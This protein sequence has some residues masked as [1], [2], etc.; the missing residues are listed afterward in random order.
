ML[1]TY[2]MEVI[3]VAKLIDLTGQRFGHLIVLKK[4]E[5]KN[6]HVYWKCQCDCGQI[7]EKTG[8]GLRNGEATHCGCQLK[9]TQ[10]QIAAKERYNKYVGQRFGRLIVIKNTGKRTS[11]VPIWLC[12]CDCGNYKEVP[13]NLLTSGHTQSCGCLKLETHLIDLTGQKIGK[14]TVLHREKEKGTKWICQCDCGN[15]KAIEGYN[16]RNG[17]TQSCG[18][19]NYSIG[20]YNIKTLLT[21][22]N[23]SFSTQFHPSDGY[24][25]YD[26]V[27]FQNDQISRF[28]EF[29]GEQH[30]NPNRGTWANHDP[31]TMIQERDRKKNEYAFSHNIPL[32]R[33][34]YWMR[35][36]ITLDILMGDTYLVK[37]ISK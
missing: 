21:N 8:Q 29:D 14:L 22:N 27:I 24:G 4:A 5:S 20:E 32:V 10:K 2:A 25:F 3:R 9:T 1:A 23:I 35:N 12:K 6:K 13:T 36:N 19:I 18:C 31:L 17:N 28:I 11:K 26:F 30:F 16:L 34:P 7:C 15:I 33:I 37:P